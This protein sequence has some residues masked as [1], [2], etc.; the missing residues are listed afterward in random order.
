MHNAASFTNIGTLTVINI[1]SGGIRFDLTTIIYLN[2]VFILLHILPLPIR[3]HDNYQRMLKFLFLFI[4]IPAVLISLID[5]AYF[6]FNNKRITSDILGVSSAG[7]RNIF[8]FLAEYWFLFLLFLIIIYILNKFYVRFSINN[9]AARLNHLIQIVFFLIAVPILIIVARGGLQQIPITPA[10]ATDHVAVQ[11]APLVTNSVYTLLYSI[12]TPGV[13]EYHFLSEEEITTILQVKK[14]FPGDS[15]NFKP[16]V[17]LVILESMASEYIGYL[18][19]GKGFTPFLDSLFKESL[20]FTNGFANAERSNKSMCVILGGIPSLTDDAIMNTIYSDNCFKGLGTEMKTMHYY[21]SFFHGGING[22]FKLDSY[23]KAA[24]FDHY[25]GKN[26]FNNDKEFDG[27]WGIYDDVF[28]QYIARQIDQ[29]PQPFCTAMFS[30]SSHDPFN[31]PKTMKGKFPKG[32]SSIIESIGYTDYSLRV[33][34]DSIKNKSWFNNTLFV[35]TADHTFGYGEHPEKYTNAAGKYSVPIAFYY[36]GKNLK[37]HDSKLAQHLDIMPSILQLTGFKGSMRSYGN[38]LFP[39]NNDRYAV[40]YAN[41][42]YQIVDDRY[43]LFFD[44]TKSIGLYDYRLDI[45]LQNNLMLNLPER[46]NK[47]ENYCKA[48]LQDY[49]VSLIHNTLCKD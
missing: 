1:L 3:N 20:V 16:N 40:Q 47:M 21:T 37:G 7:L 19:N 44:G 5:T 29:Q 43:I 36:P 14:I 23:T 22:E 39:N 34:F 4:N 32:Y 26:E 13:K 33:F 45:P 46:K 42:I 27:N 18:N 11:Y 10:N 48:L 28:F 12:K 6:P 38:S 25:F 9:T 2:I 24:G 8:H 15:S 41:N 30:L 31:I 17:V 35:I 49:H